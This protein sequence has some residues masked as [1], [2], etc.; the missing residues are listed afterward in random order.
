VSGSFAEA[1]GGKGDLHAGLERI[2]SSPRCRL[3][4]ATCGAEGALARESGAWLESPCFSVVARDTT[5]A[6]DA[7]RAGFIWALLNGDPVDQ[8][9][10][11]ANAVGALSCTVIG[12]QAGLPNRSALDRFLSTR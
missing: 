3:A 4:V 9:L 5:G 8:V 1:W 7:F 11:T 10:R 6:G 2:A 12:A